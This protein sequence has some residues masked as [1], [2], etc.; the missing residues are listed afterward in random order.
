MQMNMIGHTFISNNG[1][2]TVSDLDVVHWH[3]AQ[4]HCSVGCEYGDIYSQ[5]CYSSVSPPSLLM[6]FHVVHSQMYV[7]YCSS[8]S[9]YSMLHYHSQWLTTLSMAYSNNIPLDVWI[10]NAYCRMQNIEGAGWRETA[11]LAVT[12]VY[13]IRNGAIHIEAAIR[14]SREGK[15]REWI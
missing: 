9:V 13:S 14:A 6:V 5:Y 7:W 2:R 8:Q 1:I 12:S 4:M 11:T 3:F 10:Y 15:W